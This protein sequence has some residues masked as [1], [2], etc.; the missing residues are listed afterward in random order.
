MNEN[1]YRNPFSYC[2]LGGMAPWQNF[3]IIVRLMS[4]VVRGNPEAFFSVATKE[5]EECWKILS[6]VASDELLGKVKVVSL[7]KKSE[8][9][10][11]L[12]SQ[13]FGFLIRDD[14]VINNVS[15]P[16]KLAEYL[17]CGVNVV[18]TNAIRSYS[19]V[20]GVAGH[21]IEFSSEADVIL[22]GEFSY[23]GS[24]VSI[25]VFERHFSV[26]SAMNAIEVFL[27]ELGARYG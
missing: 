27:C 4:G 9:Q 1:V 16:I 6:S 18:T 2:Y 15:S 14:H 23:P 26:K 12:S 13:Q 3:E 19:P 22:V 8:V 25:G 10:D 20:L 7:S 21:I 17:S 5:V 24:D 11:F